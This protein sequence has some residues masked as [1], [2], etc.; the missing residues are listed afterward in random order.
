MAAPFQLH[1][2]RQAA[3]THSHGSTPRSSETIARQSRAE[4]SPQ[5]FPIGIGLRLGVPA[6]PQQAF[7]GDRSDQRAVAGKDQAARETA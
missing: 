1:Q 5:P 3:G 7:L 2:Q 6:L 4:N